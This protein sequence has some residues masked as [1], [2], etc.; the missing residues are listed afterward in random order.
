MLVWAREQAGYSLEQAAGRLKQPLEKLASWEEGKAR[1]SLRQAEHLAAVYHRPFTG[2]YLKEP[3]ITVPLASEY[4]RLPGVTPGKETPG[5][6]LALRELRRRQA[7]ALELMEENEDEVPRFTLTACAGEPPEAVGARLRER[8]GVSLDTQRAWRDSCQAWRVWRDHAEALGLLVFQVPGVPLPEMRGIALFR[9]PLPVI[10]INSHDHIASRPFTLLHEVAHLMLQHGGDERVAAEETGPPARVAELERFAD[11]V[12]AATLM[13]ATALLA[14]PL[15]RGHG[16]SQEWTADDV[17]RLARTYRVSPVAML[18]RILT[19]KLTSW[20]FYRRWRAEWERQWE[21]RP[22]HE[23]TGGPS[24]VET[25]LSRVG[26]S[27]AALILDSLERDLIS[28]LA[29]ADAFNLKFHHFGALKREL[30]APQR[31]VLHAICE[32]TEDRVQT[33]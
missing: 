13:P 23:A 21:N 17:V 26:P 2:F 19:L 9:D 16:A 11:A 29:A 5:L 25:L 3:P 14:E 7:I 24:R 27:F 20:D 28:P 22:K 32:A 15:I 12:A 18:T 1:P 31:G 10:G 33:C 6:R 8:L 4:R 30:C